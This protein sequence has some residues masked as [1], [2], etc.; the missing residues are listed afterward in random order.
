MKKLGKKLLLLGMAAALMLTL[1]SCGDNMQKD[2]QTYIQ[3]MLDKMYMGQYDQEYMDLIELTE[4]EAKADYE[5]WLGQ[6]AEMFCA[7]FDI[8]YPS[9]EFLVRVTEMYREIYSQAKY[10]VKPSTKLASGSYAVEVDVEPIHLFTLITQDDV[11]AIWEEASGGAAPEDMEDDA[12]AAADLIYADLM[13]ELVQ[14]QIPNLTY[15]PVKSVVFQIKED[16]DG[17]YTMVEDD[18]L[19]FD[20]YII[21]Y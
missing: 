21:A 5:D 7:Y 2:S 8:Y 3:G 1:V 18:L 9:D 19:T 11:T 14:A 16:T 12:Y 15:D 6:E 4:E 17:Y 20:E 13:L 10:T